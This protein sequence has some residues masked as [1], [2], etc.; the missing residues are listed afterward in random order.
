MRQFP[1]YTAVL[2]VLALA[3]ALL[4][5]TATASAQE[6][7]PADCPRHVGVRC[8]T[9]LVPLDRSNPHAGT[10]PIAYALVTHTDH[11]APAEGTIAVNPGGPG[12]AALPLLSWYLKLLG[13]LLDHHDLLLM[14]PRGTGGS[15]WLGCTMPDGL[16]SVTH[17]E[18][19]HAVGACGAQLGNRVR[20]Y[21]TA[22]TADDL[23]AVRA[24]LH[25]TRL[26]LWGQSYGS[27]LMTVY[28]QRHPTRVRSIVLDGAYPIG[29]DPFPRPNARA[30]GQALVSLCAN[31]G[32]ACDPA[33]IL[34]ETRQLAIRLHANPLRIPVTVN[35]QQRTIV[36]DDA[37]LAYTVYATTTLSLANPSDPWARLGAIPA[38]IRQALAGAPSLLLRLASGGQ[39][40]ATPAG[41]VDTS[42]SDA[43]SFS[44]ICNDY[45]AAYNRYSP[46]PVRKHQYDIARTQL[47]DSDFA[48][49]TAQ[50]WTRVLIERND[51]CL[52]WPK[53][54]EAPQSSAPPATNA[55]VL[56]LSGMLDANTPTSEGRAAAA[57]YRHATWLA[58]PNA[59]HIPTAEPSGCAV[60]I[61]R[62]FIQT[63]TTTDT[64]CLPAIPA[65]LAG[66]H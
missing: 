12:S 17:D 37:L 19:I 25:I 40:A 46:I 52:Y 56:V 23:D 6:R 35:G 32:G 13:P 11:A 31:S 15:G 60:T 10:T 43:L 50:A 30:L 59:G 2:P 21:T 18:Y 44:V 22:A 33:T 51:L 3:L 49:F 27:Y 58:V 26:D 4:G 55:P 16:A 14:D 29:F 38:A 61:A 8:G 65:V 48:P 7:L 39:P 57:A 64:A 1:R 28:A 53:H 20:N 47:A 41:A 42:S 5:I 62:R 63:L 45:P 66:R 54:S 34:R 36:Y 9:L 24:H